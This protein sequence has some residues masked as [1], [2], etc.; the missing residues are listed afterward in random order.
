M[1]KMPTI[2]VS[3]HHFDILSKPMQISNIRISRIWLGKMAKVSSF[4]QTFNFFRMSFHINCTW[5]NVG[6]CKVQHK[7]PSYV[8]YDAYISCIKFFRNTLEQSQTTSWKLY[9]L[10]FEPI[11]NIILSKPFHVINILILLSYKSY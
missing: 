3:I 9:F 6:K 1:E 8:N 2:E 10:S 7:Y 5:T 11:L 4:L